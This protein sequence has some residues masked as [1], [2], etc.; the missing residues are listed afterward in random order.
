[1]FYQHFRDYKRSI[2]H[3]AHQGKCEKVGGNLFC[4][5]KAMGTQIHVRHL[6]LED[7]YETE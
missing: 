2:K 7:K 5:M 3:T 1:M 6:I 4:L